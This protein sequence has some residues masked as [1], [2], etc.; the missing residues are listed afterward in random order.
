MA[1]LAE[2]LLTENPNR[3]VMFPLQD[4]DIWGMYKKHED[5]FGELK[6]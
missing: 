4:Q 2:P 6:K 5:C 1:Q 3:F